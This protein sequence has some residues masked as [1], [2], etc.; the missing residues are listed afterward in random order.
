MTMNQDQKTIEQLSD[1]YRKAWRQQPI[2]VEDFLNQS[3]VTGEAS[4]LVAIRLIKHEIE[5]RRSAG[6]SCA[7]KEY[8]ARFPDVDAEVL[9][10]LVSMPAPPPVSV[11]KPLLPKRYEP[12]KQIGKGGIGSVWKVDD[13]DMERTLAVK[14]LHSKL[15]KDHSANLR[16]RREAMLTGSLQH[17][18]IPPVFEYGSLVGGS[19]YFAMKLVE[20]ET[21]DKVL[22]KLT[23]SERLSVFRQ[24]AEAVGFAHSKNVIHRDLK[25][26]NVMV[27]AF[28]EVQI[29][30]W[31]M[32]RRLDRDEPAPTIKPSSLNGSKVDTVSAHC[33]E[34]ISENVDSSSPHELTRVGE[35]LGTPAYMAPEQARGESGS[36]DARSDVFGLGAILFAMLTGQHLYRGHSADEMLRIAA[37]GDMGPAFLALDKAE[38]DDELRD[39]CEDCLQPQ[40]G[41]RPADASVVAVRIGDYQNSVQNR[42]RKAELD[43]RA[44]VVKADEQRKR[45]R[46][47]SWLSGLAILLTTAGLIGV[48]WQWNKAAEAR[49]LAVERLGET[50]EAVDEFY[51]TVS[52]EGGMLSLNPGT[53]EIRKKL[54]T[55]AKDY[56]TNFVTQFAD[57][58]DAW[59][60]MAKAYERLILISSELEP[61]SDEVFV[62]IEQQKELLSKLIARNDANANSSDY[63]RLRQGAQYWLVQQLSHKGEHERAIKESKTCAE[64]IEDWIAV[65]DSLLP[66]LQAA[67]NLHNMGREKR[68]LRR[69]EEAFIDYSE[70]LRLAEP[71]WDMNRDDSQC[72]FNFATMN[73]SVAVHY[74]WYAKPRDAQKAIIHLKKS[75]EI[76]EGMIERDPKKLENKRQ[77]TSFLSNLGMLLWNDTEGEKDGEVRARNSLAAYERSIAISRELVRDHPSVPV[78]RSVL[79]KHLSSYS[80]Y[81]G[82]NGNPEKQLESLRSASNIGYNVA[83]QHPKVER[84]TLKGIQ[85]LEQLAALRGL[86]PEGKEAA[87]KSLELFAQ[88]SSQSNSGSLKWRWALRKAIVERTL[89]PMLLDLTQSFDG[90]NKKRSDHVVARAMALY[91]NNK[92]EEAKSVLDLNETKDDSLYKFAKGLVL[93]KLGQMKKSEALFAEGQTILAKDKRKHNLYYYRLLLEDELKSALE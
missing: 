5:L 34:S 28:G 39:L 73:N 86:E 81:Q 9:N 37:S 50:R 87:K 38:L 67:K 44:S 58:E 48:T 74:G 12:I 64:Y 68:I 1:E 23:Q 25:P 30:D 60:E 3:S 16:L 45:T 32:A 21:L 27:G 11:L 40:P 77:L 54:L 80:S 22:S 49:S 8:Q 4:L 82:L 83:I 71:L 43:Q 79:A 47:I 89:S 63:H 93:A 90:L 59:L 75:V 65:D 20:G 61:A 35:I 41:D 51:S 19:H 84:Y 62:L 53:A 76:M 70:A 29:M 42:L 17:P 57:D 33:D 14:V 18:G 13:R 26:Q 52:K 91:R 88:R 6:E 69:H 2:S 15:E 56:Y 72:A 10:N 55:K 92:F 24:I 78:F 46:A 66:K 31:G 85:I 36:I 7:A